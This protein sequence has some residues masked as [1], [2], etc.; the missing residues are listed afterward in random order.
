VLS[1][2]VAATLALTG[3]Q[4]LPDVALRLNTDGTVDFGSCEELDSVGVVEAEA[5]IRLDYENTLTPLTEEATPDSL[6]AG[7]VIRL[8]PVPRQQEWDRIGV[9]IWSTEARAGRKVWGIFDASQLTVGEWYWAKS[10]S[11]FE[12]VDH[13]ELD[14]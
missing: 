11:L 9:N 10:S 13:C 3:C 8:G 2:F 6:S 5:Y 12:R 7:D 4:Y 14:G 1:L